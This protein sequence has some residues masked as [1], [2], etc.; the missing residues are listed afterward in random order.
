MDRQLRWP[1]CLNV[2]D[3]GG[4]PTTRGEQTR[5]GAIVCSDGLDR[6]NDDGWRAVEAYE[7]RTIV[8]LRNDT[9]RDAERYRCDLDVLHVPIEDDTDVEFIARWRPFS[10]PHY[11]LP[12][13]ERWPNGSG[14][15]LP[16][17]PGEGPAA[18]SFIAEPAPTARD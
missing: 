16:Q 14:Q 11:Y 5:W 18:S 1:N 17:S 9:E 10:T 8:D 2:R 15:R 12:A 6:L 3:V 13:L 4:L 7:I